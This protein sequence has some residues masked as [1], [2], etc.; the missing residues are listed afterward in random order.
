MRG[1]NTLRIFDQAVSGLRIAQQLGDGFSERVG[2]GNLNRRAMFQERF[3]ERGKIF[4]V[5]SEHDRLPSE[6]WFDR[7]LT[8]G[9]SETFAHEYGRGDRIPIAKLAGCVDQ[10]AIRGAI[11]RPHCFAPQRHSQSALFQFL[12]NLARSLDMA[13]RNDEEKGREFAAQK[14]ENV[15]QNFF[16]TRVRAPAE[17]DGPALINA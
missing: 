6:N 3:L 13:G 17:E 10:E 11:A 12:L 14:E 7:V 2:I 5:R 8:T 16:L 15:C 4:H 1:E 9:S